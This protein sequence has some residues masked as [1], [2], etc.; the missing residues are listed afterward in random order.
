[1]K[2][3][4]KI[5][6]QVLL[7]AVI[8][9]ALAGGCAAQKAVR[10]LTAPVEVLAQAQASPEPVDGE[11]VHVQWVYEELEG[12]PPGGAGPQ[13]IRTTNEL[14]VEMDEPWRYRSATTVDPVP[15]SLTYAR[16]RNGKVVW[17]YNVETAPQH[18]LVR[19]SA[20]DE[21]AFGPLYMDSFANGCSNLLTRAQQDPDKL[22]DLGTEELDLWGTVHVV[23]YD[24]DGVT[25]QT[26]RYA[27]RP[28]TI[29]FKITEEE[30][31]VVEWLDI[32]HA[33]EGDVTHRHYRLTVWE[34][35][36]PAAVPD[37]LW[38]F[39]PPEGVTLVASLPEEAAPGG[40]LA[41]HKTR[42]I[43]EWT[44]P[45]YG[46]TPWLPTYLPEG[47]SLAKVEALSNLS[48]HLSYKQR[49]YS[50]LAINQKPGLSYA[51]G[52]PPEEIKLA[53]ATVELGKLDDPN[54]PPGWIA[55]V[56]PHPQGDEDIPN[57]SLL[58]EIADRD[59]AL[60][61]VESLQPAP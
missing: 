16:V 53:W 30:Q 9:T 19:P 57:I 59:E 44:V 15:G 47:M 45:D 2:E 8:V 12:L 17:E 32:I 25:A 26:V 5:S 40:E 6:V 54:A 31:W 35:L 27:G 14:W 41:E 20:E 18:A 36:E 38:T 11:I 50:P 48:Y 39:V 34:S 1:M 3:M 33:E 4:R 61:I 55:L 51:W 22:R 7:V 29:L 60:K 42:T 58:M 28:H 52:S 46:F 21:P 49:G 56:M 23:G 43:G 13:A 10:K 37:N 24:W